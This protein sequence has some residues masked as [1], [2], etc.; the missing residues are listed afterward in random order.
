MLNIMTMLKIGEGV[1][2]MV[3]H[4][5]P[6]CNFVD[7]NDMKDEKDELSFENLSF[8]NFFACD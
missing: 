7:V 4:N 6:S 3:N 5:T 1:D 8:L 2:P